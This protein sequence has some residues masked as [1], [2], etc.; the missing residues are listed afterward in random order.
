MRVL[1]RFEIQIEYPLVIL[2]Y[3]AVLSLSFHFQNFAE[4]KAFVFL[5][6]RQIENVV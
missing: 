1:Y 4:S 2:F 3:F 6:D 5:V